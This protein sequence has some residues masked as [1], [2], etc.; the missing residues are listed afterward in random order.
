MT[1]K[2]TA[3]AE[4]VERNPLRRWRNRPENQLTMADVAGRMRVAFTSVQ[5]WETGGRTPSSK[6]CEQIAEL[7]GR[8]PEQVYDAFARWYR[9]Q[10]K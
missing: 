9:Q 8:T 2:R 3:R 1:D 6:A 7:M 10:P 5:L 4:W